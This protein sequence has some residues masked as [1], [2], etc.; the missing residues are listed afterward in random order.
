MVYGMVWCHHNGGRIWNP[1]SESILW[2]Y[3]EYGIY[4]VLSQTMVWYGGRIWN[5]MVDMEWYG[6]SVGYCAWSFGQGVE[7]DL[8]I[9]QGGTDC[10]GT[11][12]SSQNKQTRKQTNKQS[13]KQENKQ[14]RKQTNK[15]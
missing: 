11:S 4:L 9:C 14:T 13:T 3:M 8:L 10:F 7:Q 5:D 15:E 2:N 12:S 6:M 1:Y